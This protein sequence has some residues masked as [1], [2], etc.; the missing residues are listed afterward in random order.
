LISAATIRV[1]GGRRHLANWRHQSPKP[2]APTT[3]TDVLPKQQF[4]L[5]HAW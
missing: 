3:K 2:P 4:E 1:V 5:D